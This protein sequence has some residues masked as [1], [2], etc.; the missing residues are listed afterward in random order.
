MTP[1]HPA[2]PAGVPLGTDPALN[3]RMRRRV[4]GYDWRILMMRL[5]FRALTSLTLVLLVAGTASAQVVQSVHVGVGGFIPKG[6]DSRIDDDV[7]VEN[8]TTFEPLL[9]RIEDFRNVNVFGEWQVAFGDRV[10]VAAGVGY[11]NES[12]PS[13]YRDLVDSDGTEIE[14]DLKLRIVPVTGVVRFM[15]FG[16]PGDVQP[17]VGA[18]L[19]LFNWRYSESGEFVDTFD[20]TIFEDR[21]VASGTEIG[22]VWLIGVRMPIQGDIYGLTVEY[23]HQIAEG[24]TGGIDAGFLA[25]KIDLGGGSFNVGFLVRF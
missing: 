19:G 23:R 22:P 18:G 4:G 25:N 2:R 8:L 7:L 20:F 17:Y 13:I 10:E 3:D 1:V 21:F 12:V 16:R 6:F 11:Y 15:P 9:F 24:E 14:Q 5:V